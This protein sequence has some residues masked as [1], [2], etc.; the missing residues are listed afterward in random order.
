VQGR[1]RSETAA[2]DYGAARKL[3]SHISGTVDFGEPD[4]DACI[5]RIRALVDKT[6]PPSSPFS[7]T[8]PREPS[9][10]PKKSTD[11]SSDPGKQLDMREYRA[12]R[13]AGEF[14]DIAPNRRKLLCGYS[15]IGGWAV[16]SRGE[17]KKKHVQTLARGSPEPWNSAAV[18]YTESAEKPHALSWTAT[19]MH[20][21]DFSPHP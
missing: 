3:H 2:E 15:R 14:E 16:G 7:H 19:R 17:S 18:I 9:F 1:D 12:H 8:K 6:A 11:F 13:D 21:A 5:A 10:P 20:P 4:D